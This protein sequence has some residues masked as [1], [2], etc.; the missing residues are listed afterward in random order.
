MGVEEWRRD[1]DFLAEELERYHADLFRWIE[2]GRWREAVARVDRA[3]DSLRWYE[4]VA[5]MSRLTAMVGDGHTELAVPQV[6]TGFRFFPVGIGIFDDGQRVVSVP[7]EHSHALGARV[8]RIGGLRADS[9]LERLEPYLARDNELE[10]LHMGPTLL[11]TAELLAAAG[12]IEDPDRGRYVIAQE[13]AAPDTLVL[14]PRARSELDTS[15]WLRV[16]E[17]EGRPTPVAERRPGDPYWFEWLPESETLYVQLDQSRDA[18]DGPSIADLAREVFRAADRERPEHL[19]FDL[20]DNTGGNFHRTRP[21]VEGVLERPWLDRRGRV[22]AITSPTTFSAGMMMALEL[23]R[24][25]E[26]LLVGRPSRGR[27]NGTYNAETF[28]LPVSGISVSYT[29]RFH[30]PWP[31]LGEA[32]RLPVDIPVPNT[33]SDFRGGRDAAMEAILAFGG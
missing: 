32:D 28:R 21:L 22:F 23:R 30:E 4:V 1:L 26:T 2:P 31:E 16:R 19:V 17:R 6:A 12:V 15:G 27:P 29:D 14:A 13:G 7:P 25:T 24:D 20:R 10:F 9:A 5:E 8:V 3:V 33:W 18:E 11:I